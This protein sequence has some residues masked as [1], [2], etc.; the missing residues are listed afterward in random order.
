MK[1]DSIKVENFVGV[2]DGTY[3]L[4]SVTRVSG[5]NGVGKTSLG[6]ALVYA[7]TGLRTDGSAAAAS[8][9]GD[10]EKTML[11]Q[12]DGAGFELIRKRTKSSGTCTLNKLPRTDAD[13]EADWGISSLAL[14]VMTW[15]GA[16]Y[17]LAE[18]KRRDLFISIA[19]PVDMQELFEQKTGLAVLLDWSKSK[20]KLHSDWTAKRQA[21][22]QEGAGVAGQIEELKKQMEAQTTDVPSAEAAIEALRAADL[23][24]QSCVA[25]IA[26]LEETDRRWCRYRDELARHTRT[27]ESLIANTAA[28]RAHEGKCPVCKQ[29]W[30]G[31]KPVPPPRM[32]DE[33]VKPDV[34]DV[35]PAVLI[36]QRKLKAQL[37]A[38][39]EA[40]RVTNAIAE[41]AAKLGTDAEARIATL[42]QIRL[43]LQAKY[44][45]AQAV[46]K[47][48]DPKK[49]IWAEALQ[50]QLSRIVLPGYRFEFVD[51]KG[52]DC[53]R[54]LREE[55]GVCVDDAS[56]GERIK[57]C[58]AL[59]GL[60]ADLASPPVRL[61]FIEHTD[62]LDQ[63]KNAP[64]FQLVAE[65]VG[66]QAD[67]AV[68]V[69]VP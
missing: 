33:P 43:D 32:P 10:P 58:M 4:G 69:V 3:R 61:Y 35:E 38:D 21:L 53:F 50:S 17:S 68:E 8:Y 1:V 49:G 51:T 45:E 11:V 40:A 63:V 56:S 14:L 67:F 36:E 52:K 18:Q 41:R 22:A 39:L 30:E 54:V 55:N 59:S 13:L 12:L 19:P 64:G 31:A 29:P 37:Y 15:P 48:L 7:L 34:A 27:C 28:I 5:R 47:A 46:E 65:R 24:Y 62:L 23:E 20:A 44:R 60:I 57:F 66:K 2:P 42:E 25:W 26:E 6:R 16:F 9:V